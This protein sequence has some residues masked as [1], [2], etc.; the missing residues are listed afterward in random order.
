MCLCQFN[1]AVLAL[2]YGGKLIVSGQINTTQLFQ[3]FFILMTMG[4]VIA[5]A[6]SLTSDLAQGGDE[7]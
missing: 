7:V 4:R 3:V 5:D 6:G 2:C 1:A